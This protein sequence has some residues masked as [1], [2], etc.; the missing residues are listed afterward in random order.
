MLRFSKQSK[1]LYSIQSFPCSSSLCSM[2][3]RKSFSFF[4]NFQIHSLHRP[5]VMM[6]RLTNSMIT[7]SFSTKD[8]SISQSNNKNLKGRNDKSNQEKNKTHKTTQNDNVS[9]PVMKQE[10]NILAI[11]QTNVQPQY[12]RDENVNYVKL[13]RSLVSSTFTQ[14]GKIIQR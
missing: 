3:N 14:T 9:P 6:N 1:K 10:E 12:K 5:N 11:P 2:I 4:G 13:K 7:R 8:T